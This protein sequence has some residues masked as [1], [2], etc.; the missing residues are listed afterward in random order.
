MPEP[1]PYPF[2]AAERLN[3]DPFYARLRAQEPM[4]RVKLPYGEAA[5]LATR[6][7]DAKVVLADPRFSRA[8]V[9]EKDEP[10]MRPGI[11]GGGILS[12]DPPD[13]TRLRRLVAK[14]FTQRRVER[15]RPRTQEIA[16]G[17]VDRMIEH[18]S[19]ADLVEEFALPLPI[20][21]IC[22]LLGVPY[23]DRDDFREW[24]DA[25][26]STTKL[27]PEQVVDYM[28]RMFGYMAGLI[29]KR[30]VDPQDDLM[31]ALIEA[32]DEHDKLTEQEMVQLAAGILVAG[33]ETTATQI[34][35]FV[36]VLLT[37]PDQ[38]EGLLAD[39]DGLPRAVEELT[40]YVPLGVAAVFAR[41]AVEDVE[42]GGVTVRAGEPVLVS[43]SSANRDEAVFDDPDR[44]DLTRENNAHI[45][46]GHGPH[47][48][49]G[50]QLARLELQ[51]GL[52]TLLTRLPGLRFAGGEDDVVWK[53]GMLVRGPSKLEVAWQSE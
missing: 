3:L 18:G 32:R 5:W 45:G 14:A 48:C 53:E 47:H 34:P 20:T 16:D 52:R 40:R 8:A 35:N 39:L 29:A 24:S 28:D 9:L 11:T 10:R 46:F 36:Y 26:L 38:L 42:L 15:L 44:L 21:V 51:V 41:Y 31:S 43:A 50:A 6:Y 1:R 12:M 49:L 27:T 30:R 4:S 37:H 2:S 33:H 19:P 17:L 23:E 25:F 13:H 7:E 22:E